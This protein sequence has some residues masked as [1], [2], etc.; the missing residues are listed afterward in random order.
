MD[1]AQDAYY[2]GLNTKIN[3]SSADHQAKIIW[4]TST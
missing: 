4:V 1:F 2:I 3:K